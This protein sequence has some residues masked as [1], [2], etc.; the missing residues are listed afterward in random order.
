MNNEEG[1]WTVCPECQGRGRRSQRPR[2]KARLSYQRA[3]DQ[4]ERSNGKNG[5]EPPPVR[6]KGHVS[7]CLDCEGTGLVRSASPPVVDQ[8]N[9]PHVAIIGGGIGGVALAVACLHRGIPF[10]LYERDS[11]FEARSQGY[12][13]TLQQASRAIRGLGVLSLEKGLIS[14]RH[15]VHTTDGKVIGEWGIRK[16]GEADAKPPPKRTN[17]HIARQSLRLALLEQLGGGGND[18]IKWGHQLVDFKEWEAGGVELSFQVDG[19][20]K[21]AKADLLVGAD[22]IRSS[23]RKLL[24]GEDVSPLHYLDCIVILGICP[25]ANLDGLEGFGDSLLDS[26]TV[27]QTANGHER[28]YMMPYDAD[29]V[30][31]QLSFPMPEEEAKA[32]SAQGAQALK[33]EACRRTQWHDPIP[34]IVAATVEAQVS[35]YPAYDR[36]LLK[37]EWLEKGAQVTLLGDAAHPMSP[38]KGQGANQALLDALALARGISKGCRPLSNWRETGIRE[39]V[40]TEFESEML[41]RTAA[42]VK[43][44]AEA[45]KF[46]HSETVLHEGDEPRGR[47]LRRKDAE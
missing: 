12:G 40:L 35:G 44:S 24:I 36:A 14:T 32:L 22:G 23:V 27:F 34:Q 3:L 31:W 18:A 6:P 2:K 26:A 11:G 9:Y 8:E 29:S 15:V 7:L 42:K 20:M 28:I 19:E 4:F 13:L 37:S 1:Y 5:D 21:S 30:M 43:D 45:A 33:D 39:S 25:L 38:F 46:L 41:E 17:V 10:T 47:C 16:W